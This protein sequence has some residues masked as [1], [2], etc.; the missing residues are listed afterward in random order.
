MELPLTG[1]HALPSPRVFINPNN[2]L[3]PPPVQCQAIRPQSRNMGLLAILSLASLLAGSS[4]ATVNVTVAHHAEAAPYAANITQVP[5]RVYGDDAYPVWHRRMTPPETPRCRYTGYKPGTEILKKGSIRREGARPL[6]TDILHL[7]DVPLKLRD[8]VVIYVDIFRPVEDGQYPTI[9]NWSPYGKE[10]GNQ[11]LDDFPGRYN[12]PLLSVSDIQKWEA[13]DPDPWVAAGY[14]IVLPDSRGAFSSEGNFPHWG[15]QMAEDGYDTIEWIADQAWSNGKVGMAGNSWLTVSQWFIAAEKP[16]HLTA[17]APWEGFVDTMRDQAMRGGVPQTGLNED[18]IEI[19]SG[20]HFIDDTVH[21]AL[22]ETNDT[23]YWQDKAAKLANID[24]PA[25]VVA[26]YENT[27]HTRGTLAAFNDIK[28]TQKWLRVHNSHE[29]YDLYQNSSQAELRQYFDHFLKGI[30]NGWN[31][32]P[33]VRISLLDPGRNEDIVNRVADAWPPTDYTQTKLYLHANKTLSPET[34]STHTSIPYAAINGSVVFRTPELNESELVGPMKLRLWVEASGAN[35]M[36]IQAIIQ[37]VDRNGHLLYRKLP[38]GGNSTTTATNY[39]RVSRRKIDP[40]RS[41]DAEPFL[42][43][44]G[45]EL[46]SKGEVVPID[47]GVWPL[48]LRIHAGEVLQ[49]TVQPFVSASSIQS[50]GTSE[51]PAARDSFTYMPNDTSVVIEK[52]G[53]PS[54]CMPDWVEKQA[55]AIVSPNHGKHI[56]HL[57]GE[58]DSHLLVPLREV[59]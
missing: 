50:F 38:Q 57:G 14:T 2:P 18:F 10:I 31:E 7:R 55:P 48:G 47:I 44:Q 12:V 35:D 30:D 11:H 56:I 4:H 17:L 58:Y 40:K 53:D 46:L 20:N 6:Q 42:L 23:L 51:I 3:M 37:K 39:Q 32:T 25:Y 15:R 28:S 21:M 24:I 49:V 54:L 8:G 59:S 45:E 33:K 5:M 29:W 26:S 19:Q 16:P 27:L 13:P 41:T 9:L 52:F 1:N 34:S 43:L 36:D 22:R